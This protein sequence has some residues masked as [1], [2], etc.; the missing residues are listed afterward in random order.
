MAFVEFGER[1][2][3]S[4]VAM[5][6]R[7]AIDALADY[8][9]PVARIR[10]L[11]HAYNTT[12]RVDTTDG[13]RFAIRLNTGSRKTFE[14]LRAEMSWLA[15]LAL[16]TDLKIPAPVRTIDGRLFTEVRGSAFGRPLLAAVFEWLPGPDLEGGARP[17]QLFVAGQAMATLHAHAERW[18]L[19][20]DATLPTL[21]TILI[22]VPDHLHDP[23][24]QLTPDREHVVHEAFDHITKVLSGLPPD[25]PRHVLHADMHLGNMK[26]SRGRLAVFDFDDCGIGLPLQDLAISSYYLRPDRT[27]EHAMAEGYATMR[28]LPT[29]TV[30][31]YEAVVAARSLV[32]LNDLLVTENAEM[33]AVLPRYAAN[34]EVKLRHYLHA[35]E[36]RHDLPGV[37]KLW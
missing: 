20:A 11:L 32:L 12:F 19:P 24:P 18:S 1:S 25:Q 21:D 3:L 30:E 28:P 34:T 4:Q 5:L 29:S 8:P 13:R 27:L 14:G 7:A 31:Q 33:R 26:W 10:L 2:Y 35:G 36:F 17:D 22:D 6:R 16:D 9:I 37:V 15:A 23:H